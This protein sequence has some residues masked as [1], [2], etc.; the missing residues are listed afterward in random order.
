MAMVLATFPTP[1]SQESC[2]DT[3]FKGNSN[4]AARRP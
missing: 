3:A 2:G 1:S 4:L